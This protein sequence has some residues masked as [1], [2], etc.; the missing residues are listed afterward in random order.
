[1]L[2]R[3]L[4]VTGGRRLSL[5]EILRVIIRRKYTVMTDLTALS[6]NTEEFKT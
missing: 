5:F 1:M 2:R 4:A 3:T 6:I